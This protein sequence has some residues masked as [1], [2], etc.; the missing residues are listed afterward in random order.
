MST[1]QPGPGRPAAVPGGGAAA[2]PGGSAAP[3]RPGS[4]RRL[5]ATTVL[6]CEAFVVFFAALVAVGLQLAPPAAVLG[7][8]GGL[9]LLC[10][11][12]AGLLRRG[13]T[14]YVLG[15]VVQV[16]LLAAGLAVPMMVVLG[17][18]FGALWVVAWRTGGRIDVERTE[19]YEAELA[20]YRAA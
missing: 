6:A 1:A 9:V 14:G 13:R 4:A 10:V 11:L 18:V 12:A 16:L 3:R 15:T 19:R 7:A 2:A 5:F 8:G 20:R 17:L